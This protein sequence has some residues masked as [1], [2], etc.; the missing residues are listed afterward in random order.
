MK[1][2]IDNSSLRNGGGIQVA[3]SFLNDLNNLKLEYEFHVIQSFSA[4]KQIDKSSFPSN[5]YFYDL[6]EIHSSIIRRVKKVKSLEMLIYPDV[7][8]TVFGP[9]YHKS[10]FPKV[11]GFAIPYLI[12]TKSPFFSQISLKEKVYFKLLGF[13][14]KF[15]FMKNSNA[16]IFETEDSRKIFMNS[17]KKE[18]DSFTVNNTLNEVFLNSEKWSE[19]SLDSSS[20]LNILSLSAN[21]AHKNLNIIPKVID[22]LINEFS[23]KDFRFILSLTKEELDFDDRYD[24]FILYIGKVDINKIPS[25]YQKI[26]FLFLPT[27]LEV[28]S[29]TYLEAMFMGKPIICSDMGFARNI[30]ANSAL[31]CSPVD[32]EKYAYNIYKLD[33]DKELQMQ[34]VNNGYQNL[35]RFGSSMDR[36]K[37]YLE[38]I[39]RYIK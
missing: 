11:V 6:K 39:N 2:I 20:K 30:C 14:K 1:I 29:T 8:F 10:N 16:L 7:I 25:L 13:F 36:T 17:V 15:F 37:S 23:M 26:D 19:F 34:L 4:S 18:L 22:K 21:Y 31:Y 27:L 9:S 3:T 35:K 24:D 5:F 32:A 33:N 12:Y 28:F 38:I